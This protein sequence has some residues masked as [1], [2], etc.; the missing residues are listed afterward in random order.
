MFVNINEGVV[1][2]ANRSAI[3]KRI[4]YFSVET[5]SEPYYDSDLTAPE[6]QQIAPLLPPEKPVGNLREV[7]L[8]KV[9]NAIFIGLTR[10]Q[11]GA[12]WV[13]RSGI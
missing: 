2:G 4:D 11:N 5:L 3:P 1:Q 13:S 8:R 9:L 6:W 10:A 7:D 12:T